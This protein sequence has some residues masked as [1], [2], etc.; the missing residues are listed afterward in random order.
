M[1]AMAVLSTDRSRCNLCGGV[2]VRRLDYMI[3]E[4]VTLQK[5]DERERVVER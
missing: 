4:G 1:R 3:P 5:K 2:H